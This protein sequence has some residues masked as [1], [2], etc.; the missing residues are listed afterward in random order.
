MNNYYSQSN[1]LA[2]KFTFDNIPPTLW[3]ARF[4][5]MKAGCSAEFQRPNMTRAYVIKS[6]LARING[7]LKDWYDAFGEYRQNQYSYAETIDA[8][9]ES[10]YWEFYG[11]LD[12]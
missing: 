4:H 2:V 8:F 3:N 7:V 11:K 5:E 10:L 12:H 1:I 9:V 6:I